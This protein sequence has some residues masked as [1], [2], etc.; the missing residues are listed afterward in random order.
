MSASFTYRPTKSEEKARKQAY[1]DLDFML[2][3][4]NKTRNEFA[5]SEGARTPQQY[6]DDSERR[7]NG[8]TPTRADQGKEEWQEN[9][10]NPITRQKL[11]AIVAGVSSTVPEFTF[12]AVNREGLLSVERAEIAH[13]LTRHSYLTGNP[14]LEMFWETWEAAAKG[15]VIKYDSYKYR[16]E[17]V[18]V[19]TGYDPVTG[20]VQYERQEH[21]VEDRLCDELIPLSEIFI[22][23]FYIH[24]IQEQPKLA[25]VQYYDKDRL[26]KEFGHFPNFKYVQDTANCSRL[27]SSTDTFY[28]KK[29]GERADKNNGLYEVFRYYSKTED[30]Y[31]IW[32]NGVPILR[33]PLLWG[34]KRKIYPFAKSIHEPFANKHFFYGKSFPSVIEGSQDINN[35]TW[36]S[37]LDNLYRSFNPKKLVGLVNKDLLD[38]EDEFVT[39]DD[40]LYVPD[41]NQVKMEP[42]R[43]VQAADINLINLSSR[44]ADLASIDPS[45][46]GAAGRQATAREIL[47]ADERARE[48][49]GIFYMFIEDLW[50]QK[51]KIR[52]QNILTHYMQ[53]K[54]EMIVGKEGAQQLQKV[55]TV[56]T[57]PDVHLSDGTMGTLGVQVVDSKTDLPN[58]TDIEATEDAMAESGI[59]YKMVAITSDYLD[60]WELDFLIVPESLE[61][62]SMARK[63]AVFADKI[64]K[65]ANYFPEYVASNKEKYFSEF[66]EIYGE[67]LD[68]YNPP[69]EA[70]PQPE[71]EGASVLGLEDPNAVPQNVPVAA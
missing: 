47:I 15:T 23:D 63:E 35:T 64:D 33:A 9:F 19:V 42:S 2:E 44:S 4:R 41:V 11:R 46:Q 68:E 36:N 3:Q 45:Q 7:L 67:R 16:K 56:F 51:T 70:P 59:N 50:L 65:A 40:I 30:K 24:D 20:R 54:T 43:G 26:K 25:W 31:E 32:V 53:Q 61:N 21:V 38:I 29:W 22:W 34:K 28:Y 37:T 62:K 18:K 1:A 17:K 71:G 55:K 48:L 14:R 60:D 8:H 39:A 27:A 69:A 57:V 66:V 13:Q 58:V 12:K 6:W 49:K 5:Y 10:F 52:V